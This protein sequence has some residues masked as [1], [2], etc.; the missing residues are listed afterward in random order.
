M[1]GV[2]ECAVLTIALAALAQ[3]VLARTSLNCSTRKVVFISAPSGETSSARDEPLSFW[4][5]MHCSGQTFVDSVQKIMPD[6][7]L[8]ASAAARLNFGA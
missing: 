5:P 8:L 6:R 2:S 7:L 4:V 3:P 1:K